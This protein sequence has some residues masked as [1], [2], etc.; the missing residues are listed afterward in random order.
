MDREILL[1]VDP[2]CSWCWGFSPVVR[3]LNDAYGDRTPIYPIVGGLAVLTAAITA[4]YLLRMFASAF[5]G[6]VNERWT[7]LKDITFAERAAATLLVAAILLLG[8][9]PSWWI[10]RVSATIAATIPG[11]TL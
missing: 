2:M 5:F 10:D 4:T 3:A 6:E 9:W 7:S 11:V 8:L 1:I